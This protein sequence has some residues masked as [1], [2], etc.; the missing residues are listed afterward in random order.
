M[1]LE[2]LLGELTDPRSGDSAPPPVFLLG[3]AI[4]C[5]FAVHEFHVNDR[6]NAVLRVSQRRVDSA[7]VSDRRE[8]R[9]R[10]G[11]KKRDDRR[12]ARETRFLRLLMKSLLPGEGT[13]RTVCR[14]VRWLVEELQVCLKSVVSR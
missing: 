1:I 10:R 4:Q 11:E 13:E 6:G 7:A 2:N 5:C 9:E 12:C 8:Y 3:Q 14:S